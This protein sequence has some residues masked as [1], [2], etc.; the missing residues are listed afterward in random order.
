MISRVRNSR[1]I[2]IN[3]S[4]YREF[5][6]L[7]FS[8][9]TEIFWKIRKKATGCPWQSVRVSDTTLTDTKYLIGP[10]EVAEPKRATSST[11]SLFDIALQWN[12]SA[13]TGL[14]RLTKAN[15]YSGQRDFCHSTA[16]GLVQTFTN[17]FSLTNSLSFPS[18]I[19]IFLFF[20]FNFP[21]VSVRPFSEATI[22]VSVSTAW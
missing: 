11:R 2:F 5:T 8:T 6:N 19:F 1:R 9:K 3:G 17:A 18:Q 15:F 14:A 13:G 12:R 4:P 21:R 7:I 10:F 22:R 20:F 16:A